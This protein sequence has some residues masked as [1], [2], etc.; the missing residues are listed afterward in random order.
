M[1]IFDLLQLPIF[2]GIEYDEVK[3]AEIRQ[4]VQMGFTD[5]QKVIVALKK[6]GWDTTKAVNYLAT[7]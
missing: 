6:W 7:H 4:I 1:K 5:R 2:V 3:E